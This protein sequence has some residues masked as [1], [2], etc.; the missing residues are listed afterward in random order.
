M[1]YDA[2][3]AREKMDAEEELQP[4]EEEHNP[5]AAASDASEAVKLPNTNT[6]RRKNKPMPCF[7]PSIARETIAPR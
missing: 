5:T 7:A 1:L 3:K 2:S 4:E 6:H